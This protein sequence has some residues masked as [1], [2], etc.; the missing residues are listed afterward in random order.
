MKFT[1]VRRDCGM[2]MPSK[3][4]KQ[5]DSEDAKFQKVPGGKGTCLHG[6]RIKGL[7]ENCGYGHARREQLHDQVQRG[8]VP[9]PS[10]LI[11]EPLG[12][13]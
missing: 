8:I 7:I 4:D 2:K 11:L 3:Q 1:G 12:D 10:S 6:W 13:H 9:L 5:W